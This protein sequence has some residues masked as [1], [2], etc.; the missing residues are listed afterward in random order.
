MQGPLIVPLTQADN[1]ARTAFTATSIL[2]RISQPTSHHVKTSRNSLTDERLLRRHLNIVVSIRA[3]SSRARP[4]V[5]LS[6]FDGVVQ[7]LRPGSGRPTMQL[8]RTAVTGRA[9]AVN[10][11]ICGC[12]L[13]ALRTLQ[14]WEVRGGDRHVAARV[15]RR[16]RRRQPSLADAIANVPCMEWDLSRSGRRGRCGRSVLVSMRSGRPG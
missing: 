8:R 13:R 5:M 7:E 9:L 15:R 10:H 16:R 12:M 2:H 1:R 14:V 4:G 3:L 6:D 11:A